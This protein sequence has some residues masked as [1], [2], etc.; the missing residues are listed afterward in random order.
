MCLF[1]PGELKIAT[2]N[3]ICYKHFIIEDNRLI[4]PYKGYIWKKEGETSILNRVNSDTGKY[5]TNGLHAFM[6]KYDCLIDLQETALEEAESC[7]PEKKRIVKTMII[8]KG[9]QYYEGI[10]NDFSAITSD[11]ML[12]AD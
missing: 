6:H 9:A 5:V 11:K 10:F 3:I 12:F 4:S 1:E 7:F 2:E 8:P